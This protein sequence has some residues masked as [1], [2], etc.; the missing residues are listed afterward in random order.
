MNTKETIIQILTKYATVDGDIW[1]RIQKIKEL[2]QEIDSLRAKNF[3][4]RQN[5]VEAIV[6]ANLQDKPMYVETR[7]QPYC[8]EVM[9]EDDIKD[10]HTI[11]VD[12]FVHE[13]S[14]SV[15][16]MLTLS[17]LFFKEE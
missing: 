8:V 6:S 12:G 10:A 11:I 1:L 5:L 9:T 13:F 4:H 16:P 17:N 3:N 7:E 14:V 15:V 2:E